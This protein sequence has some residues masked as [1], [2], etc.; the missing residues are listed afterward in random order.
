MSAGGSPGLADVYLGSDQVGVDWLLDPDSDLVS[1]L[2][3]AAG[4]RTAVDRCDPVALLADLDDLEVLIE[5]RHFGIATGE[6]SR[7]LAS[8]VLARWRHRLQVERPL[9]W[10]E[11]LGISVHELRWA[12]RDNHVRGAGE[13]EALL[14]RVDPRR[15]EPR[16]VREPG[17]V[18]E[19]SV[20]DGVLCI[21]IRQ[22]GG[23]SK[24]SQDLMLAWQQAHE[25]HFDHDRIV[26][27]LRANPGGG[28]RFIV[29]WI[30]D[31]VATE[32]VWPPW[33]EWRLAGRILNGWNGSVIAEAVLDGERLASEFDRSA[34]RFDRSGHLEVVEEP[35][36]IPA[37]PTPWLGKMLVL[38]DRGSASAAESGAW[39][40]RVGLG[41]YLI[42]GRSAGTVSFGN[43]APYLLPRSG[44]M[45][46]L[47]TA[48]A[49]RPEE[50][51]VG[52]PIDLAI[53][54]QTPLREMAANFDDIH[55]AAGGG[56]RPS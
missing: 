3:R 17:P 33:R 39:M 27:D 5:Q 40:L 1:S 42:G 50:S 19:E 12:L 16:S 45:I 35:F 53:D 38:I 26:V 10:G 32:V 52:F 44:L 21:R 51:M 7:D 22:C 8:D 13:D 14:A 15:D 54:V 20:I 41:A 31:H 48:S 46:D 28:D 4:A 37:A 43:L 56:M 49:S 11:A 47:P 18:V 9:T 34:Y 6:L 2:A 25:R 36:S 30:A 55:T 29:G 23:R 24:A